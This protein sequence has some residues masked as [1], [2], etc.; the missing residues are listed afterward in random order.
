M[1]NYKQFV[2]AT[3]SDQCFLCFKYCPKQNKDF[4]NKCK[5]RRMK[6]HQYNQVTDSASAIAAIGRVAGLSGSTAQFPRLVHNNGLLPLINRKHV[7][8]YLLDLY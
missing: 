7:H 6:S 3:V 1:S 5:P 4:Q 2:N 8:I